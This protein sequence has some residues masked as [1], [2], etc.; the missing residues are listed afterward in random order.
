MEGRINKANLTAGNSEGASKEAFAEARLS[1]EPGAGKPHAG[2]RGGGSRETGC[3]TPM[4]AAQLS[5]NA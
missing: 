4:V 5:P 2:I 1:E 3:P